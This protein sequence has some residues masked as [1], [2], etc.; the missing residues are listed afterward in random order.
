MII[1]GM[2]FLEFDFKF[3]KFH[4][5]E[6]R[7]S[8]SAFNRIPPKTDIDFG[9]FNLFS[10]ISHIGCNRIPFVTDKICWFLEI[11]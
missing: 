9:P 8:G 10:Y 2:K 5:V 4:T 11:R 6:S 7:S 1:K 3:L